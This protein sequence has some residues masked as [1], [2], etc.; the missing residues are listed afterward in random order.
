MSACADLFADNVGTQVSGVLHGRAR[1]GRD[2]AGA[3]RRSVYSAADSWG[4]KA[5][6][7]SAFSA[8]ARSADGQPWHREHHQPAGLL[9]GRAVAA[10]R[11]G[12]AL[13]T[14]RRAILGR[15]NA[16]RRAPT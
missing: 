10:S 2:Q 14:D 12:L 16:Q 7:V 5:M 6:A 1:R 9:R 4:W 8:A 3:Q 11:R 13:S 15:T